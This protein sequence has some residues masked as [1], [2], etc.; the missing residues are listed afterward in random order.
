LQ[1]LTARQHSLSKQAQ[2][3]KFL[4][5]SFAIPV[6]VS[7]QVTTKFGADTQARVAGSR[8]QRVQ[9]ENDDASAHRGSDANESEPP[10][11][12]TLRNRLGIRAER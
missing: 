4:A 1:G 3:L 7:N 12:R 5:E 10:F 9:D 2:Q 11:R 6:V 8:T